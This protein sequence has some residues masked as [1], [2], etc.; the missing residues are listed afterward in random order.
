MKNL[1]L[2]LALACSVAAETKQETELKKKLADV[3]SALAAAEAR[4]KAL[5]SVQAGTQRLTEAVQAATETSKKNSQKVD[6]VSDKV[7]ATEATVKAQTKLTENATKKLAATVEA[8]SSHVTAAINSQTE[9]LKRSL[10]EARE[11]ARTLAANNRN[12]AKTA[13]EDRLAKEETAAQLARANKS[14][15]QLNQTAEVLAAKN[16]AAFDHDKLELYKLLAG[17]TVLGAF[18]VVLQ[19]WVSGKQSRRLKEMA[20]VQKEIHTNT[21]GALAAAKEAREKAE[22]ENA[23]LKQQIESLLKSKK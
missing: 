22:A 14:L 21:N 16:Q 19:I 23:L 3:Q 18:M 2:I 15:D 17:P 5:Q 11:S 1:F 8:Q 7:D 4:N 10:A 20:G 6:E 9:Q 13:E 12:L